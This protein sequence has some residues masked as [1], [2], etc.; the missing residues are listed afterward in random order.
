MRRL[1]GFT[2]VS[3]STIA[4]AF[5]LALSVFSVACKSQKAT[6]KVAVAQKTFA[7]PEEADAALSDAT[8]SGNQDALLAIFGPEGKEVLFSGDS[9][10]DRDA[11][12][13]FAAAYD[14]MHR[15][16][17]VKAG[18]QMLYVGA[19]NFAFPVPLGQNQAGQ[20]Y[21]DTGAGKDEVLARRIGQNELAAIAA[22][23]A[24][25]DAQ[26]QY[27]SE[28]HDGD[29]TRQYAQKLASD[30]GKQ[31]GLYW[32][33]SAGKTSSP[34]DN[35]REFAEAVGYTNSGTGPFNGYYF[36]ILTKQGDKGQGGAKNY[37]VDGKMTGGFAVV[38]YPAEYRDTGIMTLMVG[39]DGVVYQ[40]DLGEN[41][42]QIAAA[43]TEYDP[44]DGWSPVL[45]D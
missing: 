33:A 37:I 30:E 9:A 36:Q 17:E 3:A 21:F 39:K 13:D 18:G 10:K 23:G 44:G 25:A 43:I 40:K 24:I 6:V 27:F 14:Q 8:R 19:D 5:A 32:P 26:N 45:G 4:M 1:F 7:S 12:Q 42:S 11:L 28:T 20:W 29:N 38:A 31:N 34:L 22:C 15:W 16:R 35:V 41:T 2:R